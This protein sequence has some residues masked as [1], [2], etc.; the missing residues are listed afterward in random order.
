MNPVGLAFDSPLAETSYDLIGE[1]EVTT[2]SNLGDLIT[3]G[4]RF[5]IDRYQPEDS[6]DFIF[7]P[8]GFIRGNIHTGIIKFSDAFSVVS[9]GT[10][11]DMERGYSLVSFYLNAQEIKRILLLAWEK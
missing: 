9:L 2:E 5:A 4:M 8:T 6:V 10:S 7:Q 1:T 11:A 3:D